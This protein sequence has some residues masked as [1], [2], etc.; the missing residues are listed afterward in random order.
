V[1][2]AKRNPNPAEFDIP[3]LPHTSPTDLSAGAQRFVKGK[4]TSKRRRDEP[5]ERLVLNL[6]PGLVQRLRERC[7]QERCSLSHAASEALEA[8]L[9]HRPE[10]SGMA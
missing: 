3:S 4:S 8:W 1:S 9:T 10:P 5:G 2:K 7:V 6:P